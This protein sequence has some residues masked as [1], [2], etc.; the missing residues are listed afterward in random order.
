MLLST[1]KATD[2]IDIYRQAANRG[3]KYTNKETH[4]GLSH[5]S[6]DWKIS[7]TIGRIAVTL[8]KDICGSQR[9]PA[10]KFST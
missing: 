6:L 2:M 7:S 9:I 1:I 3:P 4:V 8:C 10:T 5:F